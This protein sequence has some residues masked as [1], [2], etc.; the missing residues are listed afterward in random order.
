[1]LSNLILLTCL[2]RYLLV[3][4]YTI[5]IFYLHHLTDESLRDVKSRKSKVEG[6]RSRVADFFLRSRVQVCTVFEWYI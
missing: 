6:Q 5:V 4:C 2:N 3:L 1:M